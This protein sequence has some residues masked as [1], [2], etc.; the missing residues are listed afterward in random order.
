MAYALFKKLDSGIVPLG[1]TESSFSQ[2]LASPQTELKYDTTENIFISTYSVE[3]SYSYAQLKDRQLFVEQKIIPFDIDRV[4]WPEGGDKYSYS[5]LLVR[6]ALKNTDLNYDDCMVLCSGNGVQFF[7][8]VTHPL[9][10]SEQ[11]D[12]LKLSY[13]ELI[14]KMQVT[15]TEF[16]KNAVVDPSVWSKA[17]IMRMPGTINIK[18]NKPPVEAF[19]IKSAHKPVPMFLK[20]TEETYKSIPRE[21]PIDRLPPVDTDAVL[22]GCAFLKHCLENQSEV[23]EPEWYAMLSVV[24]RLDDGENIAHRFSEKHPGYNPHETDTKIRHSLESGPRTCD[25]ISGMF[26][27]CVGCDHFSKHSS[28]ITIKGDLYCGTKDSGFYIMQFDAEGNMKASKPDRNGLAN[29]FIKTNKV[30]STGDTLYTWDGDKYVALDDTRVIG[31]LHQMY[32]PLPATLGVARETYELITAHKKAV[33]DRNEMISERYLNFKNGILDKKENIFLEKTDR[34][35]FRYCLDFNYNE[36]ATCPRFDKFLEGVACGDKEIE[37]CLMEFGGYALSGEYPYYQKALIMHGMGAN[38]KSTY[39]EV[40]KML[41]GEGNATSLGIKRIAE[42]NVA[43]LLEGKLFNAANETPVD[44]FKKYSELFKDLITGGEIDAHKKYVDT[45]TFRNRAKILFACNDMPKI[46]GSD[47]AITRRIIVVPFNA[48]FR[49]NPNIFILDQLKEELPGIFNKLWRAYLAAKARGHLL[50]PKVSAT[51]IEKIRYES[52]PIRSFLVESIAL[53]E[54]EK[55]ST[56]EMYVAF[57]NYCQENGFNYTTNKI[58]F[59]RSV[60]RYSKDLGFTEYRTSTE[61]G[62]RGVKLVKTEL[63]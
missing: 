44:A 17:R 37:Q 24:S 7:F 61:R 23:T 33:V 47:D 30:K 55:V 40:L 60:S 56:T 10:S 12:K 38:G 34:F 42:P 11:Y 21:L 52:D 16:D 59:A 15:V 14:K 22:N 29:Y 57:G 27:G 46:P 54:Y 43:R 48:D 19:T 53:S 1:T 25:N 35:F 36:Q 6:E 32:R 8:E 9:I 41:A 63:I 5:E 26:A 18:K 39:L 28:P 20:V 50:E 62:Y 4:T 2:I 49:K 45:F 3:T 13:V 31:D 51:E 58:A